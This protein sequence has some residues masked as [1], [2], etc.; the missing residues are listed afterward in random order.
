MA[1]D[2]VP[3]A[4]GGGAVVQMEVARTD[5]YASS[6]GRA[7]VV[8]PGDLRVRATSPTSTEEVVVDPGSAVIPCRSVGGAG[9]SYIGRNAPGDE[10]RKEIAETT[11][12]A[13]SDLV[14]FLIKDP[15]FAPWQPYTETDDIENG[16]YQ[17][18]EVIQGVNPST[19]YIEELTGQYTEWTAYALARIDIP[20][21][22]SA[23]TDEMIK[24]LR[25]LARPFSKRDVM[26]TP[27]GPVDEFCTSALP[28]RWITPAEWDIRIPRQATTLNLRYDVLNAVQK[29]GNVFGN[30]EIRVEGLTVAS[31]PYS[32]TWDGAEPRAHVHGVNEFAIPQAWRGTVR[33][34]QLFGS[35]NGASPGHLTTDAQTRV[36]LDAEFTERIS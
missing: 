36:A 19:R 3:W 22:T 25:E 6:S 35:K 20:A 13:R 31:A 12:S 11:G 15:Q 30:T 18:I 26:Q 23:I 24:D 10:E 21:G 9:Q 1:L 14:V 17:F 32:V 28:A 7:G 16:P 5:T 4:L 8:L 33:R 34:F 2:G 29:I 27:Q